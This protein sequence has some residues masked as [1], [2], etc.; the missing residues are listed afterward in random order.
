MKP[1]RRKIPRLQISKKNGTLYHRFDIPETHG[2]RNR[3]ILEIPLGGD[4]VSEIQCFADLNITTNRQHMTNGYGGYYGGYMGRLTC[5]PI[6][7]NIPEINSNVELAN[8]LS[9]INGTLRN[10]VNMTLSDIDP[11]GTVVRKLFLVG[12]YITK[13][14]FG[15]DTTGIEITFDHCHIL[16]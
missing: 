1:I 16:I 6:I 7:V 3:T 11:T 14:W 5:E 4:G 8:R 2:V 15:Q 10:K 13:I 9:S 12:A